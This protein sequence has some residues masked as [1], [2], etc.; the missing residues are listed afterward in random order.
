MRT[1]DSR[2]QISASSLDEDS[3]QLARRSKRT[4][5]EGER[6]W[7]GAVTCA[8]GALAVLLVAAIA[9]SVLAEGLLALLVLAA[10]VVIAGLV[11]LA[12]SGDWWS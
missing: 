11:L 3:L 4:S 12:L 7:L 2:H 5:H 6:W 8:G 1:D 10:L 9:I